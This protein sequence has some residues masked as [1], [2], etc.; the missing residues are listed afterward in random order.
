MTDRSVRPA[1]GLSRLALAATAISVVAVQHP[2]GAQ[3]GA[4]WDDYG[5]GPDSAR[6]SSARQITKANV[7]RL[8]IAWSYPTR[9]NGGSLFSPVMANGVLYVLARNSSLVAIDATTGTELWIHE[10]LQGIA[11]RGINY[12]QSR[13]GRERR[14]LFQIRN[15]L[16]AIDARTGLSITAFGKDGYVDLREGLGRPAV[17]VSRIQSGTPGKV[18]ED[19]IILGSSTGEGFLSPPGDLRAFDVRTGKLAWQFGTIPKPGERGY[20]TWPKDAYK[21]IGGVNT[22]GEISVDERRGIAYFPVGSPT[23]DFYGADRTGDNLFSDCVLA[24]DARTGAYKWHFQQVHHDLWDYDPVSAPQLVTIRHQGR[25]VDVVAQAGKTGFLYVLD[26]ETGKPIWPIE[27][28]PVPASTMPGEKA[29]PTQPYPTV[30]P[31]FSRISFTEDDVNPLLPKEAFDTLRARVRNAKNQGLF[32]PPALTD[33]VS[34]PGNRGGSNWG[35]TAANPSKGMVFVLSVD[36]PSILKMEKYQPIGGGIGGAATF[37]TF[38]GPAQYR[39]HCARCHGENRQGTAEGPSLAGVDT[40]LG[41]DAI[42][43]TI[44]FGNGRMDGFGN[45]LTDPDYDA[46]VT[47]LTDAAAGAAGGRGAGAGGPG[48]PGGGGRGAGP[49]AP[50]SAGPVV[51]SG[52]APAGLRAEPSK[53]NTFGSLDGPP[54]PPGLDVPPDRYFTGWNVLYDAIKG[55]WNTLTAYDLNTGAIKWKAGFDLQMEQRGIVS[56]ATGL[57]FLATGDGRLRAYD[58]D[59]GREVWSTTLPAGNRGLPIMY[60]SAGRQFLVINAT[61]TPVGAAAGAPISRA[62]V[63]YALPRR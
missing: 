3:S 63:A 38:N 14:L 8:E 24:L 32:T 39:A 23:S 15:Q 28:R 20:E 49:G 19:L 40:R 10:G 59:T 54:Y 30:V 62:Y 6:F 47:F 27:E 48:G 55:P 16:Q 45:S 9:E 35:T 60:E 29:S 44:R 2:T 17:D 18:F 36:A 22:W 12:W 52:G 7:N 37:L 13:D 34:M 46:L 51:A 5:G 11:S 53:P 56:T 25:N 21:Y 57:V 26:R 58:E 1:W 41:V 33:T 43:T 42:A 4:T 50:V 61:Q 31:P